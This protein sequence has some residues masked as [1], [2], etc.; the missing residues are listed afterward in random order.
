MGVRIS[1]EH[2]LNASIDTCFICGKETNIVLFGAAYKDENGKRAK[3]PM[4]TCTGDI[5]D[6]CKKVIDEG[7]IFFIA[8]KDGKSDNNP[9]RTGQVSAIKEEA[10]QRMFPDFPYQKINYIEE[11]AYKQIFESVT[12]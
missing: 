6:N 8:V 3:A 4:R 7:G 9:W 5:C 2:G 12:V 10:V 11:S 1:K